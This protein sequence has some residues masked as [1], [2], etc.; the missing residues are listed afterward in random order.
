MITLDAVSQPRIQRLETWMTLRITR[1][2][3][4]RICFTFTIIIAIVKDVYL[5]I[6]LCIY[7]QQ[8][9]FTGMDSGR[10]YLYTTRLFDWRSIALESEQQPW[11]IW[12]NTSQWTVLRAVE[13][14]KCH[15]TGF[16]NGCS[17]Y[18]FASANTIY[19]RSNFPRGQ[20]TDRVI[21]LSA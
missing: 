12:V 6:Y 4:T 15:T 20:D 7:T 3:C 14:N 11:W 1:T 21:I 16:N 13:V 17:R 10:F 19:S 18:T 5:F 8:S 2:I 9:C